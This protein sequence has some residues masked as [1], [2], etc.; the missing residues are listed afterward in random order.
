M[1]LY[2]ILY[3]EN[4]TLPN[5]TGEYI[6]LLVLNATA[7]LEVDLQCT[8]SVQYLRHENQHSI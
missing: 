4:T 8:A 1:S 3:A 6:Q 7:T 2:Y 5:F